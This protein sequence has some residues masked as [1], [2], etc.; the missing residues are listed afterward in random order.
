MGSHVSSESKAARTDAVTA[1]VLCDG[2]VAYMRTSG[3]GLLQGCIMN[4]VTAHDSR[5]A[6]L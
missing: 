5:E 2:A 6:S 3:K 1:G 4:S